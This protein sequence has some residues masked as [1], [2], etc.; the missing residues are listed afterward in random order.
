MRFISK[1]I[2][3]RHIVWLQKTN[4]YVIFQ[5]P[6]YEVFEKLSEGLCET[7][8]L[9]FMQ[10][11]Y[12]IPAPEAKQFV[13]DLKKQ[14]DSLPIVQVQ[15][16]I[17]HDKKE[18][19]ELTNYPNFKSFCYSIGDKN[20]R[21]NYSSQWMMDM[22]HPGIKN[23]LT[24]KAKGEPADFY[25]IEEGDFLHLVINKTEIITWPVSDSEYF[26][27]SVSMA[28]LNGLYRK[29]E[30]NWMGT[31]HAAALEKN[32]KA[33][34]IPA[35]SGKGKST[36]AAL[37]AVN[38]FK[39]ISDDLTAVSANKQKLYCLPQAISVKPGAVEI[40]K[41]YFPELNSAKI[42]HNTTTGKDV[43]HLTKNYLFSDKTPTVSAF[44]FAEYNAGIS[45]QFKKIDNIT[46]FQK[47]IPE[48]WILPTKSNVKRF[49]YWFFDLPCYQLVY[50]NNQ[51][52]IDKIT[53]LL[54]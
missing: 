30:R 9:A 4:R 41:N 43:Y 24:E 17:N 35:A 54:K 42:T 10:E 27:G 32:N 37:L 48:A 13:D 16:K 45:F 2:K 28:L 33:V 1:R 23:F 19:A 38:G 36:L 31:F 53:Q 8:L 21:F 39:I 25:L 47:I 18:I 50:N 51:K 52:A 34:I 3:E 49:L 15:K 46:A 14:L 29:T 11:K 6:A 22:I 7:A 12:E 5:T 40:L 26:K 20:F 44:I